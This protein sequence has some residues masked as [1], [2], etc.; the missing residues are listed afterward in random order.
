VAVRD[1][2][3]SYARLAGI[4]GVVTLL[5]G[6]FGEAYVPG[7]IMVSGDA[8]ATA[9]NILAHESLFR[10]GF[11]A[12]LVEAFCDVGLTMAFWVLFGPAHRNLAFL[13]VLVRVVSTTGFAASQVLWFGALRAL[14]DA[15]RLAV[16]PPDQLHALAYTLMRLASFGGT[17]FSAFYGLASILLGWL[18]LRSGLIPKILGVLMTIM[19]AAFVLQ[20]FLVILAPSSA[21]PLLLGM[22]IVAF[23]PF[24]L[25]L[26]VKGVDVARWRELE[27]G[28]SSAAPAAAEA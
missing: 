12:Y 1:D 26:L 19:G 8:A 13:M 28:P 17:L 3:Q 14:G 21:S 6:G 15:D 18:I 16:F 4:L 10:W 22:A 2:V 11:A 7:A 9:R 27:A 23:L 20:T 25:W 5:T 24:T